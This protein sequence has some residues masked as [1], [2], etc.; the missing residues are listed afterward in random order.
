MLFRSDYE[1][2]YNWLRQVGRNNIVLC[3]EYNMPD[4]FKCI[5]QRELTCTLNKD[6]RSS[7]IEKL[8]VYNGEYYKYK[9]NGGN[10]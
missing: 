2:Y 3:S 1:E 7:R 6:S 10:E 9:K 5:W 8:F 4:D